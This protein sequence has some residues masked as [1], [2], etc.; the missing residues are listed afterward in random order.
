MLANFFNGK[1]ILVTG[2]TG[3]KGS[4][5]VT[6]LEMLG[7]N[8]HGLSLDPSAVNFHWS[9]LSLGNVSSHNIDIRNL[10][11]LKRVIRDI[12]PDIIFHLA[13]QSLVIPSY[14]QPLETWETNVIGTANLLHACQGQ[15][16]I[17]SIL[18]ATSDKCYKND[19][20]NKNFIET[21]PLGGADPYSASKASAEIVTH[22]FEKSYFS[23]TLTS[24][25]SMR[26]GNV[27]GGGDMSEY[28]LIPDLIRAVEKKDTL[29]V[30]NPKSTRPWQHV[31]DCLHGY[32][33]LAIHSYN[34]RQRFNGPWNFGPSKS[35][36]ASVENIVT[37]CK[38]HW[39]II[40]WEV[41][42]SIQNNEAKTL[43][44]NSDKAQKELNWNNIWNL[45][46]SVKETVLWYKSDLIEKKIITK[47]QIIEFTND[48]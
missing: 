15:G 34:S 39:P 20:L 27:I 14:K 31:L 13:A 45:E 19:E 24:L 44:I 10:S 1:T 40:S 48:I 12:R 47:D 28:R 11:S 43:Q 18:I 16:N 2:H 26:A 5:L 21:D 8:V 35:Q 25:C 9:K 6:W 36:I 29:M 22:S 46:K 17:G 7:A 32:L 42:G 41:E 33:L 23:E 37:I 30:R 38:N 4:W 3:F